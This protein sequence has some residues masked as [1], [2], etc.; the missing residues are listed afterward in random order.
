MGKEIESGQVSGEVEELQNIDKE[1]SPEEKAFKEHGFDY[2]V[3][4]QAR[5]M[6][7]HIAPSLDKSES[8]ALLELVKNNEEIP[9]SKIMEIISDKNLALKLA[10]AIGSNL[11]RL[12]VCT[13][14]KEKWKYYWSEAESLYRPMLVAESLKW[15]GEKTGKNNL[16]LLYPASGDDNI[17]ALTMIGQAPVA[18]VDCVTLD[19]MGAGAPAVKRANDQGVAAE[20]FVKDFSRA[21]KEDIKPNDYDCVIMDMSGIGVLWFAAESAMKGEKDYTGTADTNLYPK[22][23]EIFSN[24]LN[25]NGAGLLLNITSGGGWNFEGI[26]SSMLN[27]LVK[28]LEANGFET[29]YESPVGAFVKKKATVAEQKLAA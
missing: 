9:L 25:E 7:E 20:V 29:I 15:L 11:N 12:V 2:S 24:L 13:G 8:A 5:G 6:F 23:I 4:V 1:M 16:K 22:T 18:K 28:G 27:D 21:I 10:K 3:E 17:G 14:F 26:G 19:D